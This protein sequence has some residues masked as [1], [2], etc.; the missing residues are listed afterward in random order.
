MDYVP[1]LTETNMLH[2]RNLILEG[3]HP[4]NLMVGFLNTKIIAWMTIVLFVPMLTHETAFHWWK[5][6]MCL[7]QL[8]WMGQ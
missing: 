6:A 3:T 7:S 4:K 1:V 2:C 5:S 8:Q